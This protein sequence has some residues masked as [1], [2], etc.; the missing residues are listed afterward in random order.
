MNLDLTPRVVAF[1]P[2]ELSAAM[3]QIVL[4]LGRGLSNREIAQDSRKSV[5]T[6]KVQLVKLT[7]ASGMDRFQ[8]SVLGSRMLEAM[9][10]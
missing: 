9:A 2:L 8:L 7:Q 10:S 5:G 4:G 1:D 3:R 6:V